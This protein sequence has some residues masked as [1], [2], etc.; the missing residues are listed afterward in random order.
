M[1]KCHWALLVVVVGGTLLNVEILDAPSARAVVAK[2]GHTASTD[3]VAVAREYGLYPDRSTWS[4]PSPKVAFSE[5][6]T[7]LLSVVMLI[8]IA[9]LPR[10]SKKT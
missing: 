3:L 4:S 8:F 2:S 1:R 6:E 7:V 5:R 9:T 10:Y